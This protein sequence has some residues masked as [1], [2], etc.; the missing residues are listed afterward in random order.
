MREPIIIPRGERVTICGRNFA[1]KQVLVL[2]TWSEY[3]WLNDS[4]AAPSPTLREH[5]TSSNPVDPTQLEIPMEMLEE[6]QPAQ[7]EV[8][9]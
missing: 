3:E 6:I 4:G 5:L 2:I 1:A 9:R 7:V 8:K